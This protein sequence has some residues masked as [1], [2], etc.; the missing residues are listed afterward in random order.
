[1]YAILREVRHDF[2]CIEDDFTWH[3][4][5]KLSD[6][7]ARKEDYYNFQLGSLGATN[8]SFWKYRM[9][10]FLFEHYPPLHVQVT[11][12]CLL[13][14]LKGA[15]FTAAPPVSR[16][17]RWYCAHIGMGTLRNL[18]ARRTGAARTYFDLK[19]GKVV[20][21]RGTRKALVVAQGTVGCWDEMAGV[22]LPRRE[23]SYNS[24]D[25]PTPIPRR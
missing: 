11:G 19:Q 15:G 22:G 7:I 14:V 21:V 16:R 17:R 2:L 23:A 9:A 4:A 24:D 1:M 13:E 5:F 8:P 18:G 25:P 6:I 3:R 20:K 10:R 12:D